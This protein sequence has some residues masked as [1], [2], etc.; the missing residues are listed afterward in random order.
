[1]QQTIF[2]WN[3]EG[4]RLFVLIDNDNRDSFM[5][6]PFEN[7]DDMWE[8]MA[9]WANK[10]KKA[11][12]DTDIFSVNVINPHEEHQRWLINW[13]PKEDHPNGRCLTLT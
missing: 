5:S 8:Y 10:C 4:T 2:C 12:F 3:A 11:G 1:M 7:R 13:N 9:E 6:L